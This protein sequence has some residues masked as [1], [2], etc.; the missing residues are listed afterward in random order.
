[1]FEIKIDTDFSAAH[2]LR[3]YKGKCEGLHGHNWKIELKVTSSKLNKLGMVIDFKE[4][5]DMLE[6]IIRK[7]DH[8][9]LNKINFFKKVNPTS[10]QIAKYIYDR[11]AAK[12][13]GKFTVKKVTV[14]ES[15]SSAA[16]F[17]QV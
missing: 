13:K 6:E 3:G 11:L 5:K 7:L 14:W 2:S 9:H 15:D 4:L 1:M 16:S 10:E 12:S 8:K 17:S